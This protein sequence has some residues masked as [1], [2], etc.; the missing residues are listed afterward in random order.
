MLRVVSHIL[1]DKLSQELTWGLIDGVSNLLNIELPSKEVANLL[2]MNTLPTMVKNPELVDKAILKEEHNHLSMVFSKHLAYFTP[3]LGIIKLDI[4][5]K[6]PK[7]P[8]MCCH[9]SIFSESS[10]NPINKTVDYELSKA[11][12]GY[13]TVLK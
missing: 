2:S 8:R 12:I 10:T 4:F 7:K 9:G 1:P 5:D 6:K 13:V 11:T 3:N